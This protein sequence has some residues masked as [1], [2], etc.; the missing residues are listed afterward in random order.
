MLYISFNLLGHPGAMR[1]YHSGIHSVPACKV[2]VHV[3]VR[4]AQ[5]A[6]HNA[7]STGYYG[8]HKFTEAF[9]LSAKQMFNMDF[10]E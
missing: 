3:N 10:S 1:F 2:Q 5:L 9:P 7:L 4:G 8:N 6:T